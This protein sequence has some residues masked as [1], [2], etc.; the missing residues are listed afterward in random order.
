MNI[1]EE[2]KTYVL[3]K[4]AAFGPMSPGYHHILIWGKLLIVIIIIVIM[5]II[6]VVIK[7]IMKR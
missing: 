4:D 6:T 5:I 7:Y 2:R 1:K 3:P